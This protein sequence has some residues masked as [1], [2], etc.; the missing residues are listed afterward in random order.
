VNEH[1]QQV[2]SKLIFEE[3]EKGDA[4]SRKIMEETGFYLGVGIVS[5]LHFVNPEMVVLTG[6]LIGAGDMLMTPLRKV[7]EERALV[8]VRERLTITFA[9]LG[10][11]AGFIGAAG[12]AL[13]G[14]A[15]SAS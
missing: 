1:P 11:D 15:T 6:G 12:C 13:T 14:S 8:G 2:T 10:G 3:A 9:R 5:I 4:L 7:V